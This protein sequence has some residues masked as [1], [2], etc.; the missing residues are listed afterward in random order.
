MIVSFK[1]SAAKGDVREDAA[2]CCD[3]HWTHMEYTTAS[4]YTKTHIYIYIYYTCV[5]M[6]V[7]TYEGKLIYRIYHNYVYIYIYVYMYICVYIYIYIY[8]YVWVFDANMCRTPSPSHPFAGPASPHTCHILPPSEI[9]LG[10]CLTVFAGSGG[11][12]LFHRIGWK[13]RIWQLCS[14]SHKAVKSCTP[15]PPTR[16]LDFGGFDSS[17]LLIIMGGNSHVRWIW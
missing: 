11:K 5:Y 14:S 10:L 4:L 17:R 6:Y 1:V 7:Y 15:S 2:I 13:G 12:Y 16:S 8:I 3:V 9:D